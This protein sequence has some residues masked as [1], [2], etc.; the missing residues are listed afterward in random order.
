MLAETAERI[1]CEYRRNIGRCEYL[2]NAV[3]ESEADIAEWR[4]HLTEEMA[5][6]GGQNMDGMPHGTTVGSPT[7]RT[8]LA[9]VSGRVPIALQIEEET[10][11]EMR[12]ELREKRMEIAFVESWMKGLTAKERFVVEQIYFEKLTYNETAAGYMAKFG[13]TISRDG[14][15]R[16]RKDILMRIIE[17]AK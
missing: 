17:M 5:S 15:R 12:I 11:R 1:L 3:A 8:A 9:L 13:G 4:K 2:A 6:I 16:I 10:L 7:E 14:I